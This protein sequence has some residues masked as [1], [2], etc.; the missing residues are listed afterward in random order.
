MFRKVLALINKPL[1]YIDIPWLEDKGVDYA[2]AKEFKDTLKKTRNKNYKTIIARLMQFVKEEALLNGYVKS[3]YQCW[4]EAQLLYLRARK[5][6]M[7][8]ELNRLKSEVS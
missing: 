7:F 3:D 8:D 2:L 1:G 5:D 6:E 4:Q